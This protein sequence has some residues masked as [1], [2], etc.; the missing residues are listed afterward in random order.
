M[1]PV[2]DPVLL[3]FEHCVSSFVRV[4]TLDLRSADE[5]QHEGDRARVLGPGLRNRAPVEQVIAIG[6]ETKTAK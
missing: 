5:G 3:D 1:D 2:F 4:S 6:V